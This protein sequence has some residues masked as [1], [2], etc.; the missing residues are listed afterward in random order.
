VCELN[1]DREEDPVVVLDAVCRCDPVADLEV[2]SIVRLCCCDRV[3]V[4]VLRKDAVI[5]NEAELDFVN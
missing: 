2:N 5:R 3:F 4:F 1:P